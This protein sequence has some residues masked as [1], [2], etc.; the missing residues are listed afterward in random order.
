MD[1]ITASRN[2]G[3]LARVECT[4]QGHKAQG[5]KDHSVNKVPLQFDNVLVPFLHCCGPGSVL[6]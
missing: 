3:R 6:V 5:H 4:L 2:K 1:A